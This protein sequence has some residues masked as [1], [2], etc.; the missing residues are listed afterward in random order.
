MQGGLKDKSICTILVTFQ[1]TNFVEDLWS[2]H[3]EST[4]IVE[5]PL[6]KWDYLFY[7]RADL[8]NSQLFERYDQF[9]E[10]EIFRIHVM[11]VFLKLDELVERTRDLWIGYYPYSMD[12]MCNEILI[13]FRTHLNKRMMMMD[14]E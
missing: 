1:E 5:N 2:T 11:H 6:P 14:D 10:D 4:K 9:L 13:E 7:S 12:L 8:K 3:E